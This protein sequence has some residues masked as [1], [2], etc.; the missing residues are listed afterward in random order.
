[1]FGSPPLSLSCRFT[2]NTNV[3]EHNGGNS[4]DPV[5]LPLPLRPWFWIPFIFILVL[6]AVGLEFALHF[7][8]Q[9][10]G[11][12]SSSVIANTESAWHYL[13]TFPPV[14]IAAIFVAVWTWTDIE[15]KKMQPYVDLIQG[16]TPPHQSLLLDYTRY[17]NFFVW[18]RA[19][20]NNHY[21]VTATS[22]LALLALTFQPL[23][24]ALITIRDTPLVKPESSMN[25]AA[26]G[27]NQDDQF[28]NLTSFLTA[29]GYAG[30]SVLYGFG[31]PPFIHQGYT[32]GAF[33]LPTSVAT[34]GTV[35]VNTT[36]VKSVPNCQWV[37]VSVYMHTSTGWNNT[38]SLDDCSLTWS[39]DGP[40]GAST[41]F[42]MDALECDDGTPPKFSP[43]TFWFFMP[44]SAQAAAA[45]CAP[46]LEFW[47]VTASV[48]IM[49]SNL[50]DV[51]ELEHFSS[52][53]K[54]SSLAGNITGP[55]LNGRAYNGVN[56][57]SV[58]LNEFVTARRTA[59][60][61]QLSAA[62]F[63]AAVQSPAGL[64]GSMEPEQLVDLVT[65]VYTT[66][67]ALVASTV[68]FLPHQEK[69]TVEVQSLWKRI[70]L[71]DI[72]I[73]FLVAEMSLLAIVATLIQLFHRYGRRKLRLKHEPGTIASAVSFA[74]QTGIGGPPGGR[75]WAEGLSRILRDKR[76][77]KSAFA[78]DR[79][80][81][82]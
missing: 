73:H 47:N 61:L 44:Q 42:G 51:K 11:W 56:F 23:A 68:Y 48:D 75:R 69:M 39:V 45:I 71:N 53:S 52:A 65:W 12:P 10:N 25:L 18:T 5:W 20:A 50:T 9:S 13:F 17:N 76:S 19:L 16:D 60:Q 27:L 30:A 54:F 15:I 64:I 57:T 7:N 35:V 41:L 67:L 3:E 32:I 62:V 36:A 74:A 24:A 14:I 33:E 38:V 6:G 55:P 59:L 31:D 29:S 80:R 49:T 81:D 1:M 70:W 72:A 2:L 63:Q 8:K 28:N 66:Y 34:N 26:L 4:R 79:R 82:V 77:R 37:S 78:Q 40:G 21:L 43:V 22:L 46:T 58:D